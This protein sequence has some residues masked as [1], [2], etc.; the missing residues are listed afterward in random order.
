M[1]GEE[2]LLGQNELKVNSKGRIFIPADTKREQGEKLILLYNE[3]LGV[4]EIY[5]VK[6]IE[7]MFKKLNDNILNSKTKEE[8]IVY[9]KRLYQLSK[10]ILRC[11]KVDCQGRI[12]TGKVFEGQEKVLSIGVQDHLIIEPI[13]K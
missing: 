10:S 6:T 4:H 11:E 8:E 9:K 5:S 7:E 2:I 12:L 3:E 1:F 13:K